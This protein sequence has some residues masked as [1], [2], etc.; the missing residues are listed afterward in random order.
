MGKSFGFDA[1]IVT[2]TT[3]A[4]S[5]TVPHELG[6]PPVDAFVVYRTGSNPIYRG[7]AQWDD[8]NIYLAS[9]G[10]G[11]L[12][13]LLVFGQEATTVA[14]KTGYIEILRRT[15][16][17]DVF[18]FVNGATNILYV[19]FPI[20]LDWSGGA[21]TVKMLHRNSVGSNTV[22]FRRTSY[23]T[24]DGAA[25]TT[26]ETNTNINIT[27]TDTNT[28]LLSWSV[29]TASYALGD[30]V[31]ADF[32]RLGADGSDTNTGGMQVDGLWFEYAST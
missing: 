18:E 26:V 4:G 19:L 32:S 6:R 13:Q 22:A 29:D 17:G 27:V 30:A 16:V 1:V 10:T 9:T 21:I 14:V 8:E 3:R 25:L 28:H 15:A 7:I 23:R 20:P 31:R 24:R 5:F 2:G 11:T 12:F